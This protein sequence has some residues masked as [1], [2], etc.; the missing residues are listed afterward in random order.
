VASIT[1]QYQAEGHEKLKELIL[2][3]CLK[4]EGDERFGMTKLN[5]ILFFSDFQHYLKSQKPITGEEY[6]KLPKGPCPKYM[7]QTLR[8]MEE[9][10]DLVIATRKYFGYEQKKPLASREP[11][12]ES[13][14]GPEIAFVDSIID[15]YRLSS[16]SDV[17]EISHQFPAWKL[18][19]EN[20]EIPYAAVF[21]DDSPLSQE[22]KEFALTLDLSGIDELLAQHA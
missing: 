8:Q 12:L 13:F 3:I 14:S 4:S 18:A 1:I 19:N 11:N 6:H 20:D 10:G 7:I 2:H 22:D 17:S 5:K 9:D 15:Q 16:G 21:I